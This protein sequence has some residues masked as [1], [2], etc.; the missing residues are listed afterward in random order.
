MKKEHSITLLFGREVINYYKNEEKIP[1]QEWLAMHTGYVETFT[2]KT[3]EELDA[4]HQCYFR[5]RQWSM[6]IGDRETDITGETDIRQIGETPVIRYKENEAK[7]H[8]QFLT[9]KVDD[10]FYYFEE[11]PLE[12][13]DY[14][15]IFKENDRYIAYEYDGKLRIYSNPDKEIVTRWLEDED[16]YQDRKFPSRKSEFM[17]K[18]F[19][20]ILDLVPAIIEINSYEVFEDIANFYGCK[21]LAE[22]FSV[23][24]DEEDKEE[25]KIHDSK[26]N[27]LYNRIREFD[28]YEWI[29]LHQALMDL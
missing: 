3:K 9:H 10:F 18:T 25:M 16:Y 1:N 11:M 7:M 6:F 26:Q 20:E 22:Y 12:K 27:D 19:Q 14:R 5:M 4:F 17:D 28:F 23:D 15:G 2:F 13:Y 21:D 29:M 8:L 24:P